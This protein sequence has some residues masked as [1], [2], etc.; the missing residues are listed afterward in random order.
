M[1]EVRQGA[2]KNVLTAP[3]GGVFGPY[4]VRFML[5]RPGGYAGGMTVLAVS[6]VC[7]ALLMLSMG[8]FRR[9]AFVTS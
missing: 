1:G 7:A 8:R 2:Q 5:Q 9:F 6:C 4:A 3:L